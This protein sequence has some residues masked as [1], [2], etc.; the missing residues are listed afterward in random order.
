MQNN[1]QIN[2][3]NISNKNLL[4]Y[5]QNAT[6]TLAGG[7]NYSVFETDGQSNQNSQT[8]TLTSRYEEVQDKQ[9]FLGKLWNGIKN[10][11]GIG[12]GSNKV[13]DAIEDY[14][15]GEISY[16]EALETIESYEEKQEGGVNLITNIA[17][18]AAT[19]GIAVA[20]GG[21]SLAAVGIGAAIGGGA[22]A[23]LKTADR[24]TN[25]VKGDAF[26]IK[27]MAKDALTGAVDG[28]VNVATGGMVGKAA[29]TLGQSIKN[30]AIQGLKA[31]AISGAASGATEYTVNTIV[32]GEEFN[33]SELLSSTV[34]NAAAGGVFGGLLGGVTGAIDFKK[35]GKT[36]SNP[37]NPDSPDTS[38]TNSP[39]SP[40]SP[41]DLTSAKKPGSETGTDT[42][43]D[44]TSAKNNTESATGKKSAEGTD[45]DEEFYATPK[46]ENLTEEIKTDTEPATFEHSDEEVIS[47]SKDA[48]LTDPDLEI[49]YF[50]P[51]GELD[52]FESYSTENLADYMESDAYRATYKTAGETET[53]VLAEQSVSTHDIEGEINT[54]NASV[55]STKADT[56]VSTGNPA[57]DEFFTVPKD[58]DLT[59]GIRIESRPVEDNQTGEEFFTIP[60]DSDLAGA[61]IETEYFEPAGELDGTKLYTA[62]EQTGNITTDGNTATF[63]AA[64]DIQSEAPQTVEIN[65]ETFEIADT[66]DNGI[67]SPFIFDTH[68]INETNIEAYLEAHNVTLD[69]FDQDFIRV[70]KETDTGK[71]GTFYDYLFDS[72]S[73]DTSIGPD[74]VFYHGTTKE[75]A[76]SILE[77][78]YDTSKSVH[79]ESGKGLYTVTQAPEKG[80]EYGDGTIITFKLNSDAKIA[81]ISG[82]VTSAI[83]GTA[84]SLGTSA[85]NQNIPCSTLFSNHDIAKDTI[86]RI[87]KKM[88]YQG[89]SAST[90]NAG[91]PYTVIWDTSILNTSGIY[92]L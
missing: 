6:N 30:G 71:Y 45:G 10:V 21:I 18:G 2:P 74:T 43:T 69:E 7:E 46:D 50:E 33:T 68:K 51:A 75:S 23:G 77:N 62:D 91:V 1:V 63:E 52:D 5:S 9:G 78:G 83:Q 17:A 44:S 80:Y 70:L 66:Y 67:P 4:N 29:G 55:N 40:E 64:N 16:E 60:D 15:N 90:V 28:A 53:E 11:T 25:E 85:F 56:E 73:E 36:P 65:G 38:V 57:D 32:D 8:D 87:L 61:D 88:G 86:L 24:A 42:T 27:Q 79:Y 58:E 13:E 26:D 48:D 82:G 22:K 49:E 89:A 59:D 14:N 84:S 54:Q 12:L 35:A 76:A 81:N 92:E 31:G 72:I 3:N 41:D 37:N 47:V 19:A 20:T 34:S 39:D